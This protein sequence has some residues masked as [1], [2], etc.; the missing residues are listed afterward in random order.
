MAFDCAGEEDNIAVSKAAIEIEF[1]ISSENEI[2]I[3]RLG[4]RVGEISD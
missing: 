2:E 1:V 3:E 4:D